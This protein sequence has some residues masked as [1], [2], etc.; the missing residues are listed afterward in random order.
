ML[1]VS[2]QCRHDWYKETHL[3]IFFF[4]FFSKLQKVNKFLM[5]WGQSVWSCIRSLRRRASYLD[6]SDT[7][8]KASWKFWF[9]FGFFVFVFVF[10]LFCFL[11]F[12]KR[13]WTE[14]WKFSKAEIN[15]KKNVLKQKY[16]I[17]ISYPYI[18]NHVSLKECLPSDCCPDFR[19]N[20]IPCLFRIN[21]KR[22][23]WR[24]SCLIGSYFMG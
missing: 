11:F 19:I 22:K 9:W 4:F 21:A 15:K 23:E 10:V 1:Q 20:Y 3:Y 24:L 16:Q 5:R 7:G 13:E 17:I 8:G 2:F 14:K 18:E 12:F 6:D